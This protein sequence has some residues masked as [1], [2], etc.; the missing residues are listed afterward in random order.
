[1]PDY[2]ECNQFDF[3]R[4]PKRHNTYPLLN[5]FPNEF[6]QY[7]I[8]IDDAL[9][10]GNCGYR[11]I[12]LSLGYNQDNW[13]QIRTDLYNRLLAHSEMYKMI[14]ENDFNSLSRS[15]NFFRSGFASTPY[16]LIMSDVNF[17]IANKYGV[18]VHFLDK[19]YGS[20]ICFP[21]WQGPQDIPHHESVVIAL[22]H[23]AHY[24]KVDLQGEYLL[25]TILSLWRSYRSEHSARWQIMYN[26]RLNAY[27]P[28][29]APRNNFHMQSVEIPDN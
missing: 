8:N 1:M 4:E 11:A 26:A 21:L 7:V 17:L 29:N 3:N 20:S 14:N 18:I 22:F 12:A 24:V 27:V 9:G 13:R 2:M 6:H 23:G 25:P 16:W 19:K 15:L 28:P 10:D 5:E